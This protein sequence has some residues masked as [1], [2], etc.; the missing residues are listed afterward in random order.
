MTLK[1]LRGVWFVSSL[2]ALAALLT[3][4]AGLPEEVSLYQHDLEFISVS[5]EAF[6]YLTLAIITLTNALVY[7][8]RTLFEKE[9]AMRAWFHGLV[10][11]LNVFFVVTL[12][13]VSAYNTSERFDFQRIGPFIYASVILVMAWALFWPFR[14]VIRKIL[15]KPSV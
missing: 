3:V 5:R 4:Y 10:V 7:V 11:T 8:M 14:M 2:G 6:F 1:I 13:F 9:E 15:T 12:F